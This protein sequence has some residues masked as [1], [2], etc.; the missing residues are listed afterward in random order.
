MLKFQVL[1]ALCAIIGT[2]LATV[3]SDLD[4]ENFRKLKKQSEDDGVGG[5]FSIAEDHGAQAVSDEEGRPNY[6]MFFW[7]ED[8]KKA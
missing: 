2:C 4:E 5:E 6:S 3:G 8:G 1:F 7:S